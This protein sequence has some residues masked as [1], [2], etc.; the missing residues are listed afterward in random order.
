MDL[1]CHWFFLVGSGFQYETVIRFS[2]EA[3][4]GANHAERSAS[5]LSAQ[6]RTVP[7]SITLLP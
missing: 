4:P 1:V 7:L 2:T 3:T 5:S 6:E